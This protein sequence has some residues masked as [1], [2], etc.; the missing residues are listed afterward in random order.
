VTTRSTSA[1][2]GLLLCGA[3]AGPLFIVTVIVQD[4][5]RAGFDPRVHLMSQLALGPWGWVQVANFSLA[6]VL[7]LLYAAGL[8]RSEHRRR[9]G[10]LAS[11]LIGVFGLFLVLVGVFRTD[12]AHGFPPGA[13]TPSQPSI[14][15]VIHALGALFTFGSLTAAVVALSFLHR[16]RGERSMAAYCLVS[17]ILLPVIFVGGMSRQ[18]IMGPALQVAVLIGWTAP[19]LTA[20]RLRRAL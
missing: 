9:S 11:V 15:A 19:S 4:L 5:T 8:W 6:G 10:S 13:A 2:S 7:N 16:G 17:G 18:G 14:P 12:P 1:L 3:I 20:V